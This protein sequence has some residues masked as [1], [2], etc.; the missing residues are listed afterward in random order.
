MLGKIKLT[1]EIKPV[2]QV[3]YEIKTRILKRFHTHLN[4]ITNMEDLREL[5]RKFNDANR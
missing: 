1:S 4:N 2:K 5:E 3:E